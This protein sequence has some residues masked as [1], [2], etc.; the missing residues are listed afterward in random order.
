MWQFNTETGTV[1]IRSE[2][3]WCNPLHNRATIWQPGQSCE[4]LLTSREISTL[5]RCIRQAK[6]AFAG[7]QHRK[8]I[9]LTQKWQVLKQIKLI[10]SLAYMSGDSDW[11]FMKI[12][13]Q[14]YPWTKKSL[15]NFGSN[16]DS[17]TV[18]RY[19]T[20]DPDHI[21]LGRCM[22]SLTALVR[23]EMT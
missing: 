6:S 17:E 11:I 15:L 3:L 1:R 7:T 21:L 22:Q 5:S 19:G 18:S 20:P 8:P 9:L 23:L 13:P 2:M 16:Q 4:H 10:H 12:L 14:M